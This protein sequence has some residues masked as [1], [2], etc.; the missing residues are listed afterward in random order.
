MIKFIRTYSRVAGIGQGRGGA[1]LD[2]TV[3]DSFWNKMLTQERTCER[4]E[5]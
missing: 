3:R 2:R 5:E 4:R 1:V